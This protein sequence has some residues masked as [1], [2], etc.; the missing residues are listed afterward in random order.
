MDEFCQVMTTV[1]ARPAADALAL[2]VVDKKL[3][4]CAQ[5][6][7]PI[8]STYRWQGVVETAQEWQVI[9]KTTTARY[10]VL[11]EHI[12]SNHS[13]EVPEILCLPV[14]DGNPAYLRWVAEQTES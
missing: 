3:A 12:R 5:V 11:A 1:D 6:S 2:G 8:T 10:S 13:Y 9:F 4:A 14:V 7:G